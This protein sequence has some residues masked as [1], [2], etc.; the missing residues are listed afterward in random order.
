LQGEGWEGFGEGEKEVLGFGE[1][2]GR[3][4]CGGLG[5]AHERGGQD[6]VEVEV[7]VEGGG[8]LEA[9]AENDLLINLVARDLR[10]NFIHQRL[11]R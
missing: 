9:F 7:E 8:I 5:L 3:W 2:C 6:E 1:R 4:G 11:Q 10:Q